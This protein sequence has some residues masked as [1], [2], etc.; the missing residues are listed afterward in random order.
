MEQM[1]NNPVL[2]R[3]LSA[4]DQ[5][6]FDRVW[7]RVMGQ[8]GQTP[9]AGT[10][11]M[12]ETVPPPEAAVPETAQEVFPAPLEPPM[13][14]PV[15]PRSR[16]PAP[17]EPSAPRAM[18]SVPIPPVSGA[19]TQYDV[20]CLGASSMQ[21]VPLLREMLDGAYG[22]WNSY[23][24][25]TRQAQGM[26]ARQLR[27]LAEDQQRTLRQLGAVYFL[28]TGERFVHGNHSPV[29]AGPLNSALREMFV[30]EQ[31]WRRAYTQAMDEVDDPCLVLLFDELAGKTEL[32]MDAIRRI[33]EGL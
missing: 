5:A 16:F 17:M 24:A 21:Y 2:E 1:Q 20:S 28:L 31:R 25:M 12:P 15:M 8:S 9:E 26:S 18:P 29:P 22:T 32:H 10:A 4:P 11:P 13:R 23:R 27:A 33:L 7:N 3:P 14:P 6:T 30:R 19:P